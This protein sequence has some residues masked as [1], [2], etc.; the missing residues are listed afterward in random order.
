MLMNGNFIFFISNLRCSRRAL[1]ESTGTF[2]G[3]PVADRKI[4]PGP[5]Q[6]PGGLTREKQTTF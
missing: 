5:K 4:L 1:W 3:V 2:W 6:D